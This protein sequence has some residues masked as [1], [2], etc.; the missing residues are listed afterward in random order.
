MRLPLRTA[1]RVAW[2]LLALVAVPSEHSHAVD[3][4]AE[5][6]A[7]PQAAQQIKESLEKAAATG[8]AAAMNDLGELY[9]EGKGVPQDY[10]K[11]KEWYE[12]AAAAGNAVAMRHLG[13]LYYRGLGV[14]QDYSKAKA[15]Y[16][17]AAASGDTGAMM[18]DRK[19]TR[20][21]SSHV[22]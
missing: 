12:K 14:P 21:N 8:D 20:L 22:R 11:A 6:Q 4:S 7:A 9:Y 2:L 1:V 3:L 18:K 19:S 10:Q 17:K 13:G 15:W 16:K 5:G